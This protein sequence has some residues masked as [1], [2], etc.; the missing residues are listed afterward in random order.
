MQIP[1]QD[2]MIK[3]F[4]MKVIVILLIKTIKPTKLIIQLR[5]HKVIL[6]FKPNLQILAIKYQGHLLQYFKR[7]KKLR[8]L[9]V[10]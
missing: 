4:L 1:F 3:V 6:A 7:E 8:D 2:Y 9:L 5:N 10:Q